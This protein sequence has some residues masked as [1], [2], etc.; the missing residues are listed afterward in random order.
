[1]VVHREDGQAPV[2]VVLHHGALL[3]VRPAP[4][5]IVPRDPVGD[6][7]VDALPQR[8]GRGTVV[9]RGVIRVVVEDAVHR[10]LRR[11][12]QRVERIRRLVRPAGV[13]AVRVEAWTAFGRIV[14]AI[15]GEEYLICPRL[16][17]RHG[18]A[19]GSVT[20][21]PRVWE[22]GAAWS[23]PVHATEPLDFD[24]GGAG[25]YRSRHQLLGRV[26]VPAGF[27]EPPN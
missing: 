11:P 4:G 24:E 1:M 5:A 2:L 8:R 16:S 9:G 19:P 20:G 23:P 15:R 12:V 21:R 26:P 18:N 14:D 22:G 3:A 6:L 10:P 17:R 25:P 7:V 27:Q 13:E